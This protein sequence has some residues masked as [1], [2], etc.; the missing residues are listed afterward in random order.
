MTAI[1]TLAWGG[2]LLAAA[3]VASA[4]RPRAEGPAVERAL[5]A[6]EAGRPEEAAALLETAVERD[7]PRRFAVWSLLGRAQLLLRRPQEALRSFEQAQARAPGFLPARVGT[8]EARL[9]LGDLEQAAAGLEPLAA[10]PTPPVRAIELYAGLKLLGGDLEA[11]RALWARLAELPS[12]RPP[13]TARALEPHGAELLLRATDGSADGR[14]RLLLAAERDLASA[15]AYLALGVERLLAGERAAAAELLRIALEIDEHD[16]IVRLLLER[17]TGRPAAWPAAVE[18][19]QARVAGIYAA[20]AQRRLAEAADA[21]GEILAARPNHAPLAL[22]VA[23]I[24]EER[25][26]P[27]QALA[28]YER[29]LERVGDLPSLAAG[30]ARTSLAVDAHGAAECRAREALRLRPGDAGLLRLLAAARARAGARDEAI[31]ILREAVAGTP[32]EAASWLQLGDL[33][34]DGL[35]TE[36]ALEAYR[37]ALELEPGAAEEIRPFALAAL[38]SGADGEVGPELLGRYAERHP[39]SVDTLYTVGVARLREGDLAG[40]ERVFLELAAAAPGH[41]QV[42]YNLGQLYLRQGRPEEGRAQMELFRQLKAAEDAE[43]ERHNRAH[44]RRLEARDHEAAGR[45][46]DAL[47][48]YQANAADG[49]AEAGDY[50]AIARLLLAGGR[51]AEARAWLEPLHEAEPHDRGTLE[52]LAAIDRALGRTADL[53]RTRWQLEILDRPCP[54]GW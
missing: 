50:L 51:A 46:P 45:L 30:A 27:W 18:R 41:S 34:F 1:R 4:E 5:A 35:R 54:G 24:A 20:W 38:V 10:L 2:L 14:D 31:A 28:G 25:G 23:R 17:A 22:L 47:A 21:A 43:W 15:V 11:A 36:E 52:L 42:A 9:A 19:L 39:E 8:A 3:T 33:L 49:T 13:A 44:F 32:A 26:E 6:L 48:L 37:R 53:E 40:A 7:G 12:E 16:P 29:L